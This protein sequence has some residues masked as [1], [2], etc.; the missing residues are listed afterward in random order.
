MRCAVSGGR[1]RP[2]RP[3]PAPRPTPAAAPPRASWL[4][5][6]ANAVLGAATPP[7]AH[8]HAAFSALLRAATDE[9]WSAVLLPAVLKAL[10]RTPDAAVAQLFALR[11][12]THALL[13]AAV[14]FEAGKPVW[15]HVGKVRMQMRAA[16][17]TYVAGYVERNWDSVRHAVGAYK[18]E[19][20][21]V[22]LFTRVEGDYFH[23]LGMPL[24]ELLAFL[25]L[26]GDIDQ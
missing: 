26:R 11:G 15:R 23:V 24:L 2:R 14:I 19:E 8:C 7:A 6:Y 9:E 12:D 18:L 21:G 17:D 13:S 4:T 20:E 5:F 25:T 1:K 3:S 22:R 10:K 16:S